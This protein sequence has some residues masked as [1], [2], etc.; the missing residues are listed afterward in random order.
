MLTACLNFT[1][2]SSKFSK[3]LC[4]FEIVN[5]MLKALKYYKDSCL[6]C[7]EVMV[8]FMLQK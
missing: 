7:Y 8:S 2:V 1:D 6:N 3:Q 4:N 5:L